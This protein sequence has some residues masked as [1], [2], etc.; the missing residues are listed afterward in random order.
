MGR[1]FCKGKNLS[2][3]GKGGKREREIYGS[4]RAEINHLVKATFRDS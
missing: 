3:L 1:L 4:L 2:G